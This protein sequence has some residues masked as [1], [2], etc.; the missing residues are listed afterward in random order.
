MA[1]VDKESWVPARDE[2]PG[3]LLPLQVNCQ[4]ETVW[5]QRAHDEWVA[6]AEATLKN[7]RNAAAKDMRD[8]AAALA[9]FYAEECRKQ[10]TGVAIGAHEQARLRE[11]RNA[12]QTLAYALKQLELTPKKEDETDG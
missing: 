5:D 8:R 6:E 2:V 7:V 12:F 3:D 11:R 10:S 4:C 9:E 1:D